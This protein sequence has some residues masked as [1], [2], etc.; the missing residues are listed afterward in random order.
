[1]KKRI[2]SPLVQFEKIIR[3][4]RNPLYDLVLRCD[5]L[6]SEACPLRAVC[7]KKDTNRI[8]SIVIEKSKLL[9]QAELA[10]VF[11]GL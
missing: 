9:D 10:Q 4:G 7:K 6:C 5:E 8:G 2:E 11:A 3:L 1:M